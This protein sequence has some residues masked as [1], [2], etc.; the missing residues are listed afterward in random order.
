MECGLRRVS[1]CVGI[2]QWI[3]YWKED[4]IFWSRSEIYWE[5]I[6]QLVLVHNFFGVLVN[7]YHDLWSWCISMINQSKWVS[8]SC[9]W[10]CSSSQDLITA[11]I[12]KGCF[13]RLVYTV[14]VFNA[15][16]HSSLQSKTQAIKLPS[17]SRF[18]WSHR[19]LNSILTHW[20][21]D[22]Q[23]GTFNLA[24]KETG[25]ERMENWAFQLLK[26]VFV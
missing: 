15:S 3:W 4:Q 19:N 11:N 13:N 18:F 8:G 17:L 9:H 26:G 2:H 25:E 6:H 21:P 16:F 10:L 24:N 5:R 20:P 22:H 12:Q 23:S 7:I 1:I 14:H